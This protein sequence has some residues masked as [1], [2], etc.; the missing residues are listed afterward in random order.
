[1]ILG[2]ANWWFPKWLHKI[3]PPIGLESEDKLPKL[4]PEMYDKVVAD[5]QAKPGAGGPA[6]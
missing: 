6:F 2:K 1:M 3:T 5:A 4:T